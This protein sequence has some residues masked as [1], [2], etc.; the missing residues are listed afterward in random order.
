MAGVVEAL[1]YPSMETD[2]GQFDPP[3]AGILKAAAGAGT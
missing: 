1:A 3:K 2:K